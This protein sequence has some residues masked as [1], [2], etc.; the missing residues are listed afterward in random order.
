MIQE[1]RESR[2]ADF[3]IDANPLAEMLFS[4][5]LSLGKRSAAQCGLRPA[6]VCAGQGDCVP[7]ASAGDG[8]NFAS[9]L[10]RKPQNAAGGL[11]PGKAAAIGQ[12]RR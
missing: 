4:C 11:N 10:S 2:F 9:E 6:K 5:G 3:V 7:A 8:G 1:L 12:E